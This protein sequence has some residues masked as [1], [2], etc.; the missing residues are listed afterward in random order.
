MK[1]L[2]NGNKE[3]VNDSGSMLTSDGEVLKDDE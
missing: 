2:W 1:G 3:A